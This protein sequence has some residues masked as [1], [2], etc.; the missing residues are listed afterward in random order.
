M[1]DRQRIIREVESDLSI[2]LRAISLSRSSRQSKQLILSRLSAHAKPGELVALLGESGVGKSSLIRLIAGLESLYDG[3]LYAMGHRLQGHGYSCPPERRSMAYCPQEHLL[4]PHMTVSD[5]IS[6][7]LP[8]SMRVPQQDLVSQVLDLVELPKAHNRWPHELSGGQ[9]RRIAL[10]RA[11]ARALAIESSLLLLDEPFSSLDI[12][13][14]IRIQTRLFKLLKNHDTTIIW[15]THLLSHALDHADRL[16]VLENG[17]NLYNAPPRSLYHHPPSRGVAELLGEVEWFKSTQVATWGAHWQTFISHSDPNS[18]P[19]SDE[20]VER[21]IGFRPAL[22]SLLSSTSPKTSLSIDTTSSPLSELSSIGSEFGSSETL[23][24][25]T[26][27][28]IE[29]RG[30]LFS[31]ELKILIDPSSRASVETED[32][33]ST[34]LIRM[35]HSRIIGSTNQT[36]CLHYLGE[37]LVYR[38]LGESA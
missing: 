20:K 19:R 37:P 1:S 26:G 32:L 2:E 18:D 11:L 15:S 12:Q 33:R 10:A 25:L 30:G 31:Q 9:Q 28:I 23:F 4:F 38:R 16:W 17:Q 13:L 36:V 27:V 29:S 35:N 3:E 22:W 7:A 14:S 8:T 34:L 21:V 24:A 5:N 6:L